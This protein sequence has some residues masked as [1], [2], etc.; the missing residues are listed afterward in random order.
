MELVGT[1]K[2]TCVMHSKFRVFLFL[3][4][5]PI[6]ASFCLF[7]SFSH[8]NFKNTNWKNVD[9]VLR[10][11]T[12]GGLMVGANET[13]IKVFRWLDLNCGH[14]VSE[15][16]AVP[17]EPQPLPSSLGLWLTHACT[18]RKIRTQEVKKSHGLS[19]WRTKSIHR[20][21]PQDANANAVVIVKP[22]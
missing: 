5:G 12:R 13:N 10:I 8:Y 18:K 17:T 1:L 22:V 19:K 9:G 4:N 21:L 7:S 6:P 11:Q 15:A 14:L 20:W 2:I 3:K 16:T